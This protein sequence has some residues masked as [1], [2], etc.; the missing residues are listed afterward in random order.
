MSAQERAA[1]A[2][3]TTTMETLSGVK[4]EALLSLI[5]AT[6]QAPAPAHC[7]S[8]VPEPWGDI[9]DLCTQK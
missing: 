4:F 1:L 5:F 8:P 9:A 6:L 7:L 2:Q 3:H